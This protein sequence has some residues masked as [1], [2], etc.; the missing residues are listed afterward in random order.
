M[1]KITFL[2][3]RRLTCGSGCLSDCN[4]YVAINRFMSVL[5]SDCSNPDRANF[6]VSYSFYTLKADWERSHHPH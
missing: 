5:E 6:V 3:P 2:Q 4:A 1:Q